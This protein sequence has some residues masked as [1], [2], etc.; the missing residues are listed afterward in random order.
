[1]IQSPGDVP[2]EGHVDA[3]GC[4]ENPVETNLPWQVSAS[5]PGMCFTDG[6]TEAAVTACMTTEITVTLDLC[7]G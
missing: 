2:Y 4:T 7:A 6:A 3:E 1:M 5:T